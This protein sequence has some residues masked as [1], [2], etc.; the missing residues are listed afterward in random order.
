MVAFRVGV[1]VMA[2]IRVRVRVGVKVGVTAGVGVRVYG[3]EHKQTPPS[4]GNTAVQYANHRRSLRQ[5]AADNSAPKRRDN[6][7]HNDSYRDPIGLNNT[8]R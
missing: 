6:T 7:R 3:S 4:A 5:W 1:A 2:G 8:N